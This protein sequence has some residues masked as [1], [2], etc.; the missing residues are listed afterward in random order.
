MSL[1]AVL[2]RCGLLLWLLSQCL[3]PLQAAQDDN[4]ASLSLSSV[5]IAT[6]LWPGFTEPDEQGAYFHL[7]TLLF[8]GE[9][10]FKVSYT[11]F[12]RSV[13]MVEHQQADMVLGI[14]LK[15][16]VGLLYSALPFDIDQVA[17]LFQPE[18][19]Q[20]QQP[21]DLTDQLIAT[22]RG[23]NY[24]MVL[25]ISAQ[26]YE[27]DSIATG[28]NLLRSGRVD[29][30]LVE[31]AELHAKADIKLLDGISIVLL[32]GEQIYIGFANNQRGQELKAWWDQQFLHYYH[33]EQLQALY[34][35]Y[36]EMHLPEL[37]RYQ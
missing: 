16:S 15:D 14:G 13:Q 11:S 2:L 37:S 35:Q 12:N 21:H 17:V 30:F 24:D 10:Q 6:G 28:L 32:G 18:R 19:L 36:E 7:I 34:Q 33:T 8:P 20:I 25:G 4:S 5:H 23:Y 31:K 29:A 26:S 22:Q 9:T 27:V 1:V 3:L